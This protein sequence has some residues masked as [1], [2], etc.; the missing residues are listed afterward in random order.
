MTDLAN[1]CVTPLFRCPQGSQG[2]LEKR[3]HP[4]SSNLVVWCAKIGPKTKKVQKTLELTKNVK[5]YGFSMVFQSSLVLGPILVH[6]TTKFK[7]SGW[8]C[9]FRHLWGHWECLNSGIICIWKIFQLFCGCWRHLAKKFVFFKL[10]PDVTF[11]I[12]HE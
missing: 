7:L 12:L 6:Q 5:N 11:I 1:F 10:K 2:C 8:F 3:N 9:F 4:L